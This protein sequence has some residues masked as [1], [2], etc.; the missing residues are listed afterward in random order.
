MRRFIL[1]L[2]VIMSCTALSQ[3]AQSPFQYKAPEPVQP[4]APVVNVDA[5][6]SDKQ[7]ATIMEMIQAAFQTMNAEKKPNEPFD[8][9]GSKAALL[10]PTQKYI[11]RIDNTHVVWDQST[12]TYT[13]IDASTVDR[14]LTDAD[15]E[16]MKNDAL[17]ELEKLKQSLLKEQSVPESSP[18]I[19][20][21]AST[22]SPQPVAPREPAVNKVK[23]PPVQS[24]PNQKKPMM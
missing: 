4:A 14:F 15:Y 18:E 10:K 2:S 1:T 12:Q 20:S 8:I 17:A 19:D 9:G 11:G 6:L 23:T 7:R 16:S 24:V 21:K 5:D 22:T 13:Y 3:T